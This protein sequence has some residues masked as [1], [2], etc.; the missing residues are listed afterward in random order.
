[1]RGLEICGCTRKVSPVDGT[2]VS[3]R[4]TQ[5][6]RHRNETMEELENGARRHGI[7]PE[8]NHSGEGGMLITQD[9]GRLPMERR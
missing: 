9:C 7:L 2:A 6:L 5:L 8:E 4:S 1:M 3:S